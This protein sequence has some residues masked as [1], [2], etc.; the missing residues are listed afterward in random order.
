MTWKHSWR[1]SRLLQM[2]TGGWQRSGAFAYFPCLQEKRRLQQQAYPPRPAA[3]GTSSKPH[4]TGLQ[5]W[6]FQSDGGQDL[7]DTLVLEQ[8]V[9]AMP[10]RTREW[11]QCHRPT[12]AK[13]TVNL[14]EDHL[15]VQGWEKGPERPTSASRRL[16][17]PGIREGP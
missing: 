8:F 7:L 5:L 1:P 15:A 9:E 17:P 4:W 11:I 3:T 13:A 16:Q 10:S 2:Q 14:A 12:D 6:E